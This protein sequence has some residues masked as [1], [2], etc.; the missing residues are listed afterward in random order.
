MARVRRYRSRHDKLGD[1]DDHRR[2]PTVIPERGREPAHAI[3]GGLHEDRG[4]ARRPDG[5]AAGDPQPREHCLLHQAVHGTPLQRGGERT[6]DRLLQVGGG[7]AGG[8]PGSG[9]RGG[10]D[11]IDAEF[12]PSDKV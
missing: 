9:T 2:E 5:P 4:A 8:Q 11:V 1:R 6:E 10:E 12:K 7:A 3:S